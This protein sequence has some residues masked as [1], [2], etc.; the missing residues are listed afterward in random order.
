MTDDSGDLVE[1]YRYDTW[2]RVLGVYD[3]DGAPP[4]ESAISSNYLFQGRWCSWKMGLYYFRARWYDPIIGRWLS[5]DPIGISGG[6]NQYVFVN[7]NPVNF[8]DPFGL[9]PKGFYERYEEEYDA[10][11]FD[12]WNLCVASLFTSGKRI[13]ESSASV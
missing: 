10:V 3:G 1:S 9:C 5:K 2:D 8:W 6:L 13:E 4:E 12:P 11:A 7:N